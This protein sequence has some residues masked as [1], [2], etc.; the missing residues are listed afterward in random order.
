MLKIPLTKTAPLLIAALSLIIETLTPTHAEVC[1]SQMTETQAKATVEKFQ[2]RMKIALVRGDIASMTDLY[3][4]TLLEN[5]SDN[6]L[7]RL[8]SFDC[9]TQLGQYFL[10][11]AS[12]IRYYTNKS[13][14]ETPLLLSNL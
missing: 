9:Y 3:N 14:V 7:S 5:C 6:E 12:D 4:N 13:G 1:K 11:E 2:Q 10:F 8:C